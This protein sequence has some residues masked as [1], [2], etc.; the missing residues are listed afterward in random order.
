MAPILDP[1]ANKDGG[2][3]PQAAGAVSRFVSF[4]FMFLVNEI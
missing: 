3:K 4:V 1:F 2:A